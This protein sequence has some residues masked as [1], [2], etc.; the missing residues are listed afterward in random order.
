MDYNATTPLDPAVIR[1][2]SE[3]LGEAWGNPSSTNVA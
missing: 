2:V 1:A 3:A